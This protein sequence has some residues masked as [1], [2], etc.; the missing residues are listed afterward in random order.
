M[1]GKASSSFGV[2]SGVAAAALLWTWACSPDDAGSPGG[3]AAGE[4]AAAG[5]DGASGGAEAA[6]EGGAAGA[7]GPPAQGAFI[8][9]VTAVSP[10]VAG[11]ACPSGAAFSY[12]V[13]AVL[14]SAPTEALDTST[15]LHHVAH[16]DA[17]AS[18]KCKV[19]GTTTF[20]FAG[21]ISQAGSTFDLSEGTL[22]ADKKGVARITLSNSEHLASSLSSPV[23]SC[24][25]E[26]LQVQPGAM[27]ATFNCP[28]VESPPS[29]S[30][31]AK[32]T[33]VLENCVQ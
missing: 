33:F 3:G 7:A 31:G 32:G 19:Q 10:P 27:W 23:A 5:T 18:V 30:C 25:I 26:A 13:P 20:A 28:S 11:K 1:R 21:R 8:A 17:G 15:Y 16:G 2:W 12:D 6:G 29:D 22:A 4:P 24:T 9:Q 14:S